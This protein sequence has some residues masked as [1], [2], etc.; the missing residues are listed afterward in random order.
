MT[1][2]IE[3]LK[4]A[5]AGESQANRKYL[6]FAKKADE[7]GY[8]QVAKL[9]RA[10]AEAETIH[11]HNHLRAIGE[12]KTTAENLQAAMGGENY[13]VNSMYPPML[14]EAD[15]VGNKPASRSFKYALEV[16][17]VHAILYRQILE[18]LGKDS[19][20]FDYYICPVCGFTHEGP[21]AE[22]CPVCGTLAKRFIQMI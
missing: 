8:P 14:A 18:N 19:S 10:V 7:D 1:N 13:E 21:M 11:A 9:F 17:K 2:T 6:A 16:E 4:A 20:T 22:N 3:N 5:F 15:T 12:V